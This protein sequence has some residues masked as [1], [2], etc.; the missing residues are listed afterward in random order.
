MKAA[1]FDEYGPAS[2]LYATELPDPSPGPWEVRVRVEAAGVCRHDVLHRAGLLPGS[3][4]GAVLGHEI[5]GTIDEVGSEVDDIAVGTRVVVYHKLVCGRCRGCTSGRQ[6]LCTAAKRMGTHH[7][8]GYAQ[9][10]VVPATNVIPLPEQVSTTSAALS[11]CPIGTSLRGLRTA[12]A[13]IGQSVAIV[14]ASGGLGAHQIQLATAMGLRAIAVVRSDTWEQELRALGADEVVVAPDGNFA[15]AVR[16]AAG[17]EGVDIVLDNVVSGT[18]AATLRSLA[19]GGAAVVLGNLE[20]VDQPIAP[21]RLIY[22]RLRMIGSGTPTLPDVR[23]VIAAMAT[24]TVRA[25]VAEELPL[26]Q[27]AQAHERLEAG[28]TLGRF[29]LTP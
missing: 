10:A 15:R 6:D 9:Y 7:S 8:G 23:D 19:M 21:G 3:P 5:A 13:H 22:R 28:G 24:G 11:I 18:L 2:V 20:V 14:G 17:G 16:E 4:A 29:V 25:L 1:M 26:E 12:G 27:A